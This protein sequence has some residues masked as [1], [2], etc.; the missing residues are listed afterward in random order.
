MA[1]QKSNLGLIIAIIFAGVAIAGSLIFFALQLKGTVDDG[2]DA[3]MNDEELALRIEEGIET[4]V[5]NMQDDYEAEVAAANQPVVVTGDY[6]D[7]DA[8]LG[9]KDAPV[10]I[11]EFSDYQC[12]F[13][14]SF[15]NG[16][17]QEIEEKYLDSGQVRI[18]FRDFPLNFHEDALPAALAAECAR[19]QG[20]DEVYFQM[21]DK[22][23]DGQ[24]GN[25][26]VA[27]PDSALTGYAE[28]LGLE[29]GQ[30]TSCVE[31]EKYADEI[32]ADLEAGKKA[33]VT[34]TPAFLVNGLLVE[35]AQPF[36]VFESAIEDAL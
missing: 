25:G 35:G 28:D 8:F 16:A 30:F 12:P 19:E 5:A 14:R 11:V 21:H 13:C 18:V 20:G 23:F 15:Y 2:D 27:I 34:G 4:Y 33:G 17:Y 1:K 26:T 6:S 22:I 9:D 7:D 32:A 10:T 3:G 31:S 29:M 36:S 24:S